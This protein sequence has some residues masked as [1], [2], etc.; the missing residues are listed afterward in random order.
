MQKW[1]SKEYLQSKL[2][3]DV[4]VTVTPNGL[5]DAILD[6]KFVLPH[7]L[8]MPIGDVLD[9]ITNSEKHDD[10]AVFYVQSQNNNMG[11]DADFSVLFQDIPQDIPFMTE[12]LGRSPDAVNLWI[13]NS[14]AVTSCHKDHYENMYV[15]LAGSKTFTLIPPT[16]AWCLSG[17]P[18]IRKSETYTSLRLS[19][20]ESIFPVAKYQPSNL[21]F[22]GL[23]QW[24]IVDV[25]PS[26]NTPW[27]PVNVIDPGSKYP[28]FSEYCRPHTVML[29]AGDMLYLPSLWFHHVQQTSEPLDGFSAAIAINY[30]YD[31]SFDVKHAYFLFVK[32][33]ESKLH[34]DTNM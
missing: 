6:D 11:I 23:T 24:S 29:H 32:D 2:H 13:G 8:K 20:I 22:D 10:D 3:N 17:T 12:A 31:M 27:I 21:Q 4:T 34:Q 25:E 14:R 15:V 7:E 33:L 26:Q 16:E 28:W 5:A 30:W 1:T 18:V 19:S 9:R